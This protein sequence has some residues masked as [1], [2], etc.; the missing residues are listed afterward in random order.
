MFHFVL[1]HVTFGAF[2][3]ERPSKKGFNLFFNA[4][5]R[6]I[7]H[8]SPDY[9]FSTIFIGG[10]TPGLL[11]SSQILRLGE[12]I[13]RQN[14]KENLEW[15]VEV[16]PSEVSIEKL[17]SFKE[18]GI[19]RISL[20]V[21]TFDSTL[22]T[23][24]GRLHDVSKALKAYSMIR[25][26]GFN[27]VNLD[28][29]FGVPGQSIPM[30]EADLGR[31]LALN[32]DHIS[33]Y[34]LTF[35]EDTAL[36]VKLSEGKIKIDPDM[37]ARFYDKTWELLPTNGYAQYEVSNFAR[38][39]HKCLHNLNTWAMNEWIGYGP[40]AASQ[41][42]GIRRKNFSNL[43]LWADQMERSSNFEFEEHEKLK[44]EDFAF[45]A[46]CF[47]LRMNDGIDLNEIGEKFGVAPHRFK[48][49]FRLFTK[50]AVQ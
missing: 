44:P 50:L 39:G 40:S 3:Q 45:D 8:F 17:E 46:I 12:L 29:I 36:Y 35:E 47:G 32:P 43:K 24:L 25:E 4:L 28:L 6:E 33:T 15:S 9:S 34:C 7:D 2:Y 11:D 18:I 48:K 5:Q 23:A 26:V 37:E 30:W 13:N 49:S 19:T 21:Q 20:G 10:G 41:V 16:A 22:M 27:S 38:E 14:L 31:A 1:P 42:G